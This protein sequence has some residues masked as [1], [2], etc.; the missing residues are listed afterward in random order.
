VYQL[1]I[2]ANTSDSTVYTNTKKI[3]IWSSVRAKQILN[4]F[5]F[6]LYKPFLMKNT[7]ILLF[8][9]NENGMVIVKYPFQLYYNYFNFSPAIPFQIIQKY[10]RDFRHFKYFA[11]YAHILTWMLDLNPKLY[12]LVT[13][14]RHFN[15]R[16]AFG[17]Q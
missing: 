14:A 7:P 6:Y 16:W 15:D 13:N 10:S 8:W 11:V 4:D 5:H 12:V 9:N 17:L 1:Q 3:A 2:H